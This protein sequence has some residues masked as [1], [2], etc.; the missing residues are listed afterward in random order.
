VEKISLLA[1]HAWG[2]PKY[3]FLGR[4]YPFDGEALEDATRL[5]RTR[6]ILESEGLSV[7]IGH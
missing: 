4:D 6:E 2:K 1:Y 5:E 3:D 7:T